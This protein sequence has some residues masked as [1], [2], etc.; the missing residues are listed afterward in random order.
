MAVAVAAPARTDV[1][2]VQATT[3]LT[4]RQAA[5]KKVLFTE[6]TLPPP[7]ASED[8]TDQQRD[9]VVITPPGGASQV[10][11][12][13]TAPPS[14]GQAQINS[15]NVTWDTDPNGN[16]FPAGSVIT[17]S[18]AVDR[19][20]F[21]AVTVTLGTTKESY[22]VVSGDD[23]VNKVTAQS[24]LVQ[25]IAGPYHVELPSVAGTELFSAGKNGEVNADYAAVLDALLNVDAHIIVAA[26]Q[27]VPANPTIE[28]A[29]DAHCQKAS[30]D[31]YKRDR[32]AI[33]GSDF[34]RSADTQPPSASNISTYVN[35]LLGAPL[36][37]DRLVFVAPGFLQQ[38]SVPSDNGP[39]MLPGAYTAAAIAGM[40]AALPPHISLTNKSVAVARLEVSFNT[41]QLTELVQDGVTALEVSPDIRVLRGQTTQVQ[42]A[43]REITTRRIV[44]YAKYG[45]R[46][47]AEPYIG[48]L[49]NDRVRA[50]LQ[51][52]VNSFLKQM[53]DGEMLDSYSLDVS[54]TREQEIAGIAQVTITLQPVF[55][56]NF[57]QVT[58]ILS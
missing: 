36:S 58:M 31:V 18:Y 55:S 45:V 53:L 38:S 23:L 5:D 26:G 20:E 51:A 28:A 33:I 40:L 48:L 12:V 41:A 8:P 13:N 30:T 43:F 29:L 24:S 52:T 17:V 21:R 34:A 25:A 54:A 39:V 56:I 35:T 22:L 15:G 47:A 42:G 6:F 4:G 57:I 49:N 7:K 1:L 32:I 37:S 19:A 11:I 44:D 14:K 27:S 2:T 3:T 46:S 16:A 9:S 10:L 50:A